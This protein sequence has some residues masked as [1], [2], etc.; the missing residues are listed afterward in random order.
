MLRKD[1]SGKNKHGSCIL[2][3]VIDVMFYFKQNKWNAFKNKKSNL[4]MS[5]HME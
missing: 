5:L 4:S 1:R 3:Q 2:Y